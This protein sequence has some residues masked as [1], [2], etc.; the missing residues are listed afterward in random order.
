MARKID[1]W[2]FILPNSSL[3]QKLDFYQNVGSG[4]KQ[5]TNILE[6]KMYVIYNPLQS[7]T[8]TV[9]DS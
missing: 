5:I 2:Q 3:E 6:K 1:K 4:V 8:Q 9:K 7:L